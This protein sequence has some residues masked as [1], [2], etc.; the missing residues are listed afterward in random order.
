MTILTRGLGRTGLAL[1]ALAFAALPSL[2]AGEPATEHGGR[3]LS[4]SMTGTVE[5]PAGD[6]DGTGNF[7]GTFNEGQEQLCY[8]L[9]VANIALPATAAHIHH[10]PAGAPGPVVIP[11]NTPTNGS[12]SGCRQVDQAL[13][14]D[15]V[16][17]PDAYYVNV[18]NSPY[19]A[20]AVRG[21]LSK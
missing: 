8:T 13:L 10:A 5:V 1:A 20:G 17:H 16:Q 3:P 18:H 4:T 9:S 19:P 7:K 21:Q 2:A 11:L 14:K 12:S 15:I 6:P